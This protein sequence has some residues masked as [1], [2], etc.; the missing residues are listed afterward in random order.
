MQADQEKEQNEQRMY[1]LI[2]TA[3]EKSGKAF[4]KPNWFEKVPKAD[5]IKLGEGIRWRYSGK[6]WAARENGFADHDL[7]RGF[8]GL[9]I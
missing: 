1:A 3:K 5:Q 9:T 8:A 7:T 4:I 6:Y 2:R